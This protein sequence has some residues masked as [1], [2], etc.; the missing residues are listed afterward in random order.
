MAMRELTGRE[1]ALAKKMS[2]NTATPRDMI[3]MATSSN[4]MYYDFFTTATTANQEVTQGLHGSNT[5]ID[6]SNLSYPKVWPDESVMQISTDFWQPDV[7]VENMSLTYT[8]YSCNVSPCTC[9]QTPPTT[10]Y[11]PWNQPHKPEVI[12]S[13][14]EAEHLRNLAQND[15]M[16]RETLK[17][18]QP[19]IAVEMD[20]GDD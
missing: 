8:C 4:N 11:I 1:Y 20:F 14:D 18:F 9:W 13:F 2:I 7:Q 17:K 19:Y 3:T 15:K 12:L 6:W 5:T 16:L 10:Y